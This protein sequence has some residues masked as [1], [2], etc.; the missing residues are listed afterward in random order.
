MLQKWEYLTLNASTNYG[1][2]KFFVN[3]ELQTALKNQP[4]PVVLNQVGNKGWEMVGVTSDQEG[5]TY[6]FKRPSVKKTSNS[7]SD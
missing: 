7:E 1:S 5:I 4:L 6:Y 2:T 3:G